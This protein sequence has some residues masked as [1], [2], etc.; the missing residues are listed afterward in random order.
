MQD[1]ELLK[2]QD[3]E[4]EILLEFDQVCKKK[5]IDY[6]LDY[7]TLL[8]AV[9]HKGFIPW[10]DDIDVG[11]T[12]ENYEKFIEISQKDLG[13]QYFLESYSTEEKC[14]YLFSKVRKNNT[15]YMEWCHRNLKMHHGIYIDIF[16]YD[17]VPMD[18]REYNTLLKLYKRLKKCYIYKVVPECTTAPKKSIRWVIKAVLRRC[19][20]YC[21]F[22]VNRNALFNKI[23]SLSISYQQSNS[24]YLQCLCEPNTQKIHNNL[25]YPLKSIKFEGHDFPV[26][27]NVDEYLKILYGDYQVLPPIEDRI[28]HK[29]HKIFFNN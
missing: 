1:N 7:G 11:M 8:G 28:G 21:M 12:R 22:F 5:E 6:F 14:P 15:I 29:P 10:D 2:I 26:P 24:H 9:R 25:I 13:S 4:L 27:N 3:I 16:P 18:D 19:L 20:H 17:I 23:Y